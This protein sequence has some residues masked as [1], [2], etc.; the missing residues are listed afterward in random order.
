MAATP[1]CHPAPPCTWHILAVPKVHPKK[2][3]QTL[4]NK[5]PPV[6]A[7]RTGGHRHYAQKDPPSMHRAPG[8]TAIMLRLRPRV[9]R[10]PPWAARRGAK[11]AP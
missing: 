10:A 3:K 1:H 5:R 7:S 2:S 11:Y 6:D 9:S 4:L 8:G